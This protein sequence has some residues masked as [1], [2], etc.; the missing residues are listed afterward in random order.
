MRCALI[1]LPRLSV[2]LRGNLDSWGVM[3]IGHFALGIAAKKIAPKTSLGALML[4]VGFVDVLWPYFLLLGWEHVRIDPG[5][6]AFTPLDLYDYPYSHSLAMGIVWAFVFGGI[7]YAL[8]KYKRGA[9]VLGFGVLSHWFLDFFTHRPDMPLHLGAESPKVGLGLW[10]SVPAT[11]VELSM[12]ALA[13][14][15]YTKVTRPRDRIGGLGFSLFML[16][17]LVMYFGN[18]FG[19]LPPNENVIAIFGAFTLVLFAIPYWI[20]RHREVVSY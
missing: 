4:S 3:F 11:I 16:F 20:D 19:P 5:N 10:N 1:E 17:I 9:V 15:I 13:I 8:T 14:W 12:F 18:T 2:L 7:Y 6:T